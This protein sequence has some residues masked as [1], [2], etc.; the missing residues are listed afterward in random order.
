MW[1]DQNNI[2]YRSEFDEICSQLNHTQ[3]NE[4]LN[5]ANEQKLISELGLPVS[6]KH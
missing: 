1:Q 3:M 6:L 4:V 5:D 2:E